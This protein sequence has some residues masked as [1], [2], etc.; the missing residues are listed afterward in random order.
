MVEVTRKTAQTV[1]DEFRWRGFIHRTDDAQELYTPGL[2]ELLAQE[3]VTAYIG[4]DPSAD[5]LHL[6]NLVGIMALVHLQEYGH[7]PIAI[8]GGGTG[9]IGDPGGKSEER[10]LLS[11]E[12]VE[13]NVRGIH[14]QLSRYLEFRDAENTATLINNADWLA[15]LNMLDFLREVGKH[16]TINH[17]LAKE[18]VQSRLAQGISY[19]EF[20]YMLLHAF[21]YLTLYDQY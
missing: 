2:D 10:P 6:G 13:H 16:F 8:A 11:R 20:S 15:P 5:S 19:T 1:L 21:D 7:R 9:M 14:A 18:S 3:K 4:F 17:M 12:Q